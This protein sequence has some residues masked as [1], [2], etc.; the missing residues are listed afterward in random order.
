MKV[1]FRNVLPLLTIAVS[2]V[3]FLSGCDAFKNEDTSG[4]IT[5]KGQVL[6]SETNNPV[7]GAVV[8]VSPYDKVYEAD[9]DGLFS[10][11]LKID[12][13]TTLVVEASQT[14]FTSRSFEVLAIAGRTVEVPVFRLVQF[15]DEIQVSGFAA[16]ILLQDQSLESIGVIESGSQEVAEI[17]FLVADST[18]RPV[19]LDKSTS[20]R[21]TFGSAPGGG[22]YLYPTEAKTDNNGIAT[23]NL[24][25]G[26]KAGVVQIVAEI[27]SNGT[28]IRSR[29]VVVSIHGG[30]P[31]QAHFS[32]G[33]DRF[34]FPGLLT[35][36]LTNSIS[37]IVGDKFSNPVRVG[38]SV[39][40]STSHGVVLG[41]IQTNASGQGAVDLI[42]ANPLPV[43]GIALITA[44]S[45]DENELPVIGTTP[46]VFSGAPFVS[47][48][49]SVAALDQ[50]Y[51]LTV[52]DQNGNPLAPGTKI[53]VKVE[54]ESVKAVGN[55]DVTLDDTI[56]S[57][58]ELFEHVV[59]GYGITQFTFRAVSDVEVGST[60]IPSVEAITILVSGP[61]GSL[62]IVLT[63]A[64]APNSPTD[65]V[66]LRMSDG[67]T[68]EAFLEPV[69][70]E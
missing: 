10:E 27:T 6:N 4:T 15:G 39:Y 34:N 8:R 5:L 70:E 56:F 20:V 53:S 29:P 66:T 7:A 45:A 16:N 68:I 58:G 28:I 47:V 9:E 19:V 24:S 23:V 35:F 43:D 59:R 60:T 41:S 2:S 36:G 1:F 25:S 37:V 48:S 51:E 26:T 30:L 11:E 69:F 31:D 63:P 62:E 50:T 52:R 17:S 32:I 64:G 3:L 49:P 57:G 67:N 55:T 33:P 40:F 42:S 44:E 54:G 65:G 46:V 12:S 18:G 22:E 61:N 21:F 14:G 38:T 13:T